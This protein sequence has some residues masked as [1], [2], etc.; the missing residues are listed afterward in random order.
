M[1]RQLVLLPASGDDWRLDDRTREIGRK[2]VA[3]ARAILQLA[4]D[5][6][7]EAAAA[8]AAQAA[9]GRAA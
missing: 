9:R 1:A 5:R 2:G 8:E 3:E 7:R 4:I 6:E